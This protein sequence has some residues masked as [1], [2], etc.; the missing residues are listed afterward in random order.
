MRKSRLYEE[1]N[2]ESCVR[3][4]AL[5]YDPESC[6]APTIDV[7]GKG[8][9]ARTIRRIA[10]RY[11]ITVLEDKELAEQLWNDRFSRVVSETH[12]PALAKIFVEE[13]VL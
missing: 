13:G 8:E 12:Y 10:L 11:G 9:I 6:G 4:I 3:A 7:A 5:G 1:F 2:R